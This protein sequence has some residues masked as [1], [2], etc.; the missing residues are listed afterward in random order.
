LEDI[1]VMCDNQFDEPTPPQWTPSTHKR[2]TYGTMNTN[3]SSQPNNEDCQTCIHSFI[4]SFSH[5]DRNVSVCLSVRP[6]VRYAP[7]L[8]QNEESHDFF[9]IW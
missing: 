8:C 2:H 1:L 7:V 4:H 5:S 9:T 3:H 6:S